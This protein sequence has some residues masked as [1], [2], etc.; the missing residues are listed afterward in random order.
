MSNIDAMFNALLETIMSP[1]L[2]DKNRKQLVIVGDSMASMLHF[3]LAK[4][5]G[6]E[7]Y[8]VVFH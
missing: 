7:N 4:S 1:V 8:L 6:I 2:E 5:P 3:I